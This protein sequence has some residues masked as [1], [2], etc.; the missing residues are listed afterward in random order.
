MIITAI[1]QQERLKGRYSIFV[2]GTYAFSLSADALL[3]AKLS[4]GQE[5]D[6][7]SLKAHKK[8]SA[9]D[10]AYGLALAYVA[11]RMRSRWE[12]TEYFRR[13]QYESELGARILARLENLGLVND[14][15]FAEAWVRNRR[16]LKP[17]SRRRLTQELRQ[18][19]VADDII[20][21]VLAADEADELSVLRD[22]IARKRR[23]TKYQ[24]SLKLMQYLARQGFSYQDI[25]DALEAE[26]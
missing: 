22:L 26:G 19:R 25:K 9:D 12:L 18:K 3:G 1:K 6:E 5:L 15:Q 16:L 7:A 23:Q 24:D 10:K 20:G 13:K 8:L 4:L 17:V 2:D 14:T 11:R 21:Q